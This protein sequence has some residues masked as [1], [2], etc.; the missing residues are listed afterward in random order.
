VFG[1]DV[2]DRSGLEDL[3]ER[4]LV[5]LRAWSAILDDRT[6]AELAALMESIG[7]PS[8]AEPTPSP[9][10]TARLEVFLPVTIEDRET[11]EPT[12][13]ER[14][15]AAFEGATVRGGDRLADIDCVRRAT[16][17]S[18]E[19]VGVHEDYGFA[20]GSA[21][22]LVREGGAGPLRCRI[23]F[24]LSRAPR[25]DELRALLDVVE[26]ELLFTGWGLN[27]EWHGGPED[28]GHR[29]GVGARVEEHRLIG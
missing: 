1:L 20:H 25:E 7:L 24:E 27:L 8:F 17:G 2:R 16:G 15:L 12:S 11:D 4:C 14:V 18:R 5:L 28:D 13:D 19:I 26:K 21:V 3:Y 6:R 22:E 10:T 9:K 23:T 29:V